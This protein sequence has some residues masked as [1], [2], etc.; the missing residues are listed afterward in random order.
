MAPCSNSRTVTVS[1]HYQRVPGY[2]DLQCSPSKFVWAYVLRKPSGNL[3][4][5]WK[6]TIFNGHINYKWSSSIAMYMFTRGNVFDFNIYKHRD[7]HRS[8][9]S[10]PS[11]Q[12]GNAESAA[13]ADLMRSLPP[14]GW[15]D[16]RKSP[17][18]WSQQ[19]GPAGATQKMLWMCRRADKIHQNCY[20]I[21]MF[22]N[23]GARSPPSFSVNLN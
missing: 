20:G 5:Q 10:A 2:L 4:W 7:S 18:G 13:T 12:M 8:L 15:S 3:T 17:L 16:D 1:R 21:L 9:Q 19:Y 11:H 6:I 22:Q 23:F 14:A